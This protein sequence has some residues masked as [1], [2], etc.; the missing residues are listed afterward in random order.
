M[1]IIKAIIDGENNFVIEKAE[2]YVGEQNAEMIE[3]D[4]GNFSQGNYDFYV[5]KFDNGI[6]EGC[7]PSNV[8]STAEDEP[9]YIDNGVIYCPID[10]SHTATGNLKIQLE[11]HKTVDGRV[12]VKKSSIAFISFGNSLM[13]Q[14]NAPAHSN[15]LYERLA[16][17]EGRITDAQGRIVDAE[18]RIAYAENRITDSEARI[19]DSESRIANSEGRIASAESRIADIEREN[20]G[21]SIEGVRSRVTALENSAEESDELIGN[22]GRRISAV[23][24]YKIPERFSNL[25]QKIAV[26]ENDFEDLDTSIEGVENRVK[27]L[28][29][30]DEESDRLIENLGNRISAVEGYEIPEKFSTLDQKVA[31]L[32]NNFENFEPEITLPIAS[33][34]TLGGVKLNGHSEF[35]ADENGFLKLRYGNMDM[36]SLTAMIAVALFNKIGVVE[37]VVGNT[38]DD[39]SASVLDFSW[40]LLSGTLEAAVFTAFK[41]GNITWA[42]ENYDEVTCEISANTVCVLKVI[43]GEMKLEKYAGDALRT[44]ILEGI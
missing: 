36:H 19:T 39:I 32:E 20:F 43:D 8:I 10:A 13:G 33:D 4:I 34:N 21:S 7:F 30:S 2:G 9:A 42:N 37:T 18:N 1:R 3:I 17:A 16:D 25:N 38:V 26:L 31:E 5:L 11:A 23:E 6:S 24:G 41:N 27:V 15:P 14:G 28:E 40:R 12:T 44:L 35:S 29:S 22:L